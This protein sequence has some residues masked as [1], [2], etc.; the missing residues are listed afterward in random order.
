MGF[1]G[2]G[3]GGGPKKYGL[4]GGGGK[5]LRCKGGVIKKFLQLLQ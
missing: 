1:E 4:K 2:G 3:G 5:N